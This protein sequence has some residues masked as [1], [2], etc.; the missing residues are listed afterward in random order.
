MKTLFF[1]SSLLLILNVDSDEFVDGNGAIWTSKN[2]T[3]SKF[4]NGDEI[5]HAKSNKEWMEAF[6]NQTPAYCYFDNDESNNEKYGKLYNFYA[7]RDSRGLAPEG[8]HVATDEEWKIL[9]DSLGGNQKANYKLANN[10]FK[11]VPGGFRDVEGEFSGGGWSALFWTATVD[12]SFMSFN[13]QLFSDKES[14]ISKGS[15]HHAMG[16]YVRCVKD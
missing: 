3:V 6:D 16:M 7:V 12:F 5:S 14:S 13:R 11:F 10:G 15:S 9:I 1:I 2:L 4:R 8:W